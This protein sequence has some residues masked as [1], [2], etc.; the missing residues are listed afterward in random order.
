[1]PRPRA[2]QVVP[3]VAA[4]VDGWMDAAYVAGEYPRDDFADAFPGFT[5]GAAALATEDADLM[6]NADRGARIDGGHRRGCAPCGSTS[7]A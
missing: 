3:E 1:M 5:Q 4:V 6:T 7:S 2:E